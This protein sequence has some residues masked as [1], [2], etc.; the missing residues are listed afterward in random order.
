MTKEKGTRPYGGY[1]SE[2]SLPG[3]AGV[4]RPT[5]IF[6]AE[7]DLSNSRRAKAGRL[8]LAEIGTT[9]GLTARDARWRSGNSLNGPW[10]DRTLSATLA[11]TIIA[12]TLLIDYVHF[13]NGEFTEVRVIVAGRRSGLP[14]SWDVLDL[15]NSSERSNSVP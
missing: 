4:K 11:S 10:R 1:G 7:G 9:K 3:V 14:H 12:G 8:Q 15:P 13:G 5:P 6:A 2:A